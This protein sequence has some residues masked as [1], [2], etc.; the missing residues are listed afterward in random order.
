MVTMR[1]GMAT[2]YNAEGALSSESARARAV[3]MADRCILLDRDGVLNRNR[4]DYVKDCSELEVFP[5][6]IEAVRRLVQAGYRILVV[7]NQQCVAK[8]IV[9]PERL[10]EIHA[11]LRTRFAEGGGRIDGFYVCTHLAEVG[12]ECRKPAP[13]LIRRAQRE[14]AFE[15][16]ETWAVGDAP[17]DL[18]AAR[19]VGCR[20]VLVRTGIAAELPTDLADV[21]V[22]DDL[23]G[24]VDR[25]LP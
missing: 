18:R 9:P 24:F 10:E 15:P 21:P 23:L 16:R 17:S 13:G 19:A 3:A 8:G 4:A 22:Y 25:L 11:A 7:T 14:W 5:Q 12:C 2:G 6:A 20:A 1:M